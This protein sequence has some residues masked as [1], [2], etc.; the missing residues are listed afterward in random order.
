[1]V[2]SQDQFPFVFL[3]V[4]EDTIG[5]N[6]QHAAS[7]SRGEEG[8]N[9]ANQNRVRILSQ[10]FVQ[11]LLGCFACMGYSL[12]FVGACFCLQILF[13]SIAATVKLGAWQTGF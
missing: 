10:R 12:V 9:E 3:A 4:A 8:K 11:E 7:R 2:G 1:M 6:K 13:R 5:W